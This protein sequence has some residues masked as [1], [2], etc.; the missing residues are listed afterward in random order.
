[1]Q[2]IAVAWFALLMAAVMIVFGSSHAVH[3]CEGALREESE[4]ASWRS[5]PSVPGDGHFVGVE[6]AEAKIWVGEEGLCADER[7]PLRTIGNTGRPIAVA[8][9]S[10]IP[11]WLSFRKDPRGD[12]WVV[13]TKNLALEGDLVRPAIGK[14]VFVAAFSDVHAR[15]L[16]V[17]L[18]A[19]ALLAAL[20]VAVLMLARAIV[21]GHRWMRGAR[22]A[23]PNTNP[24]LAPY[25][26][27]RAAAPDIRAIEAQ[28]E[29]V[30]LAALA[31]SGVLVIA[32]AIVVLVTQC[33]AVEMR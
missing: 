32:G 14:E 16:D 26:S 3:F 13:Y 29:R 22:R 28:V 5:W 2:S 15:H 31:K 21:F 17:G 27:A 20:A 25:R 11:F 7:L 6:P 9:F 4:P 23:T 30:V 24:I 18:P 1:V 10:H 33:T 8:G 19:A 12:V